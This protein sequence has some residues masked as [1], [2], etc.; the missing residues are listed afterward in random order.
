MVEILN[1]Q[2]DLLCSWRGGG[3]CF[4]QKHAT[5][6]FQVPLVVVKWYGAATVPRDCL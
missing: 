4:M 5:V 1:I 6:I 3:N 2:L